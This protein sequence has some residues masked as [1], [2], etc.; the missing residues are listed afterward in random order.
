MQVSNLTTRVVVAAVGIPLIV[1]VTIA[2][3]YWF[4]AFVA[5]ISILGLHEFYGLVRAKGAAPQ[6][7]TGMIFGLALTIAFLYN[8]ISFVVLSLIDTV[9]LAVPLPSFTQF[10]V[11]IL[12]LFLPLAML[13]ELFRNRHSPLVN[14]A[15]TA[16]G[17]FY[18]SLFLGTLVGLRELYVPSDFPV[19]AHFATSGPAVPEAIRETI[20]SWG[21]VT[22]LG[23]FAAI[24][25]CDSAAYFVGRWWGKH[26][27]LERVSP[28]KTW[29]G[30]IAGFIF[31]LGT[32]LL[33]RTF[34]LPY[35]SF[36][37]AVVCGSIIG[38]FGQLGDLVESWMKRDAG[39]KDSSAVIPGHGGILDRFDSLIFVSPLLFL[40]IDFIVF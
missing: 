39:V 21:G 28:K 9:G 26:K 35:L 14:V 27:L 7:W 29:E 1:L 15:T 30:A 10:L 4:F 12:L 37:H 18:V 38:I 19:Y 3:G 32:F 34:F 11:I 40:Y 16:L 2:G 17:V 31:A 20:Y 25:M 5:L 6:V 36:I 23:F 22:V 13:V 8:K 24:W 33:V